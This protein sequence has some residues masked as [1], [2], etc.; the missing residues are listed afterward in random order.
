MR[1][2]MVKKGIPKAVLARM[3]RTSGMDAMLERFQSEG[4]APKV[5][6]GGPASRVDIASLSASLHSQARDRSI[7]PVVGAQRSLAEVNPLSAP[8]RAIGRIRDEFDVI[9]RSESNRKALDAILGKLLPG[10]KALI[11]NI[12]APALVQDAE[13]AAVALSALRSDL[14]SS[15]GDASQE[16]SEPAASSPGEYDKVLEKIEAALRA[17]GDLRGKLSDDS[18]GAHQRLLNICAS[19]GGLNM[20]R[21]RV[22]DN[23]A[24]AKSAAHA[25]DLIMTNVRSVV[26]AHGRLSPDMAK[27]VLG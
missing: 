15:G 13:K 11:D 19:V 2:N 23:A 24:S 14:Q 21:M 8:A 6:K 9:A 16:P 4:V 1:L 26:V 17:V 22:G 7:T 3:T 5:T 18:A 12:E 10:Y 27:L 25:C 20:A